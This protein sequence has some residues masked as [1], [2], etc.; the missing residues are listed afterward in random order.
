MTGRSGVLAA[1]A[2]LL[3]E[4]GTPFL[5]G[6][7][8]PDGAGK[9][10]FADEL[11]ATLRPVGR[12]VVRASVDDFHHP[13]AHRH[14]EG[15]TAETVW[16]RHFD[17]AALRRE[18][19]DPWRLG[20]GSSYVTRWHDLATDEHVEAEPQ[21]V[22]E[23]GVLIVDGLFLQREELDGVWDLVVYLDVPDELGLHRVDERDGVLEGPERYAAAQR[24]YRRLCRPRE[25]ADVVVDNA[26]LARPRITVV[27][28]TGHRR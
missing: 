28:T 10:T 23:G 11:A 14:A 13:R 1:V 12:V 20:P 15:R 24:I 9:S 17:H 3:P 21:T 5:V 26:D 18:L 2:A 19:V 27:E 7:D 4:V 16:S 22:P 25:G 8:G 6:I